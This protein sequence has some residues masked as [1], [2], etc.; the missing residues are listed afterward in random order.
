M[1]LA[2]DNKLHFGTC[3]YPDQWPRERWAIDLALMRD[4]GLTC[5]RW[6]EGSWSTC[7]PKPGEFTWD[8]YD[9]VLAHCADAG[10]GV[11]M[12]TPCCAAPIWFDRQYPQALAQSSDGSPLGRSGRQRYDLTNSA[13][14][15]HA[16]AVVDAL[17]E[18]YAGDA[19][20]WAWQVNN[21]LWWPEPELHGESVTTAF[22]AWLRDR[23][24]SIDVLNQ[25]WG[26]A[27]WSNQLTDFAQ[28]TVPASPEH[29]RN[30][31][32]WADYQRFLSVTGTQA[33]HDLRAIITGYNQHAVVMLNAPS[34]P[35][36][37]AQ[38]LGGVDAYG[39]DHFPR[40]LA[41]P[42]DRPQRGRDYG[43]FRPYAERLWAAEQQASQVGTLDT[44][45][46]T[47]PP[48]QL[49]VSALQ[50]IAHGCNVVNWFRWRTA[51]A[52]HHAN[53]G[54]LI[55]SWGE[56]SW[57][58]DEAAALI[59]SLQPHSHIIAD[60]KPQ[61]D[62]ARLWGFD[63]EVVAAAEPW[64]AT[65]LIGGDVGRGALNNLSLNEDSI[66]PCDLRPG[67]SYQFAIMPLA[68]AVSQDDIAHLHAW[69]EAGGELVLGPMAGHRDQNGQA[70][71]QCQPPGALA[72]LT[73]TRNGDC[74]TT[75]DP[76]L[77]LAADGGHRFTASRYAEVVE[78]V[79][80]D[81]TI[82]ARH[83]TGWLAA[84]GAIVER[85]VGRGKVI[86]SGVALTDAVLSW[87]WSDGPL[88]RPQPAM[89][90]H[91]AAAEILVRANHRYA[92]YFTLNHG[93]GPAVYYLHR[94]VADLMTGEQQ[95]NS[96]TLNGFGWRILIEELN[97]DQD[98]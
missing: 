5:V 76:V 45:Q 37:R 2:A 47:S 7:E 46:P 71:D 85:T 14:Q 29:G 92:L 94:P 59:R 90:T 91:E 78:P 16:A 9:E 65:A 19:R 58:F 24:A 73:G 69:V 41:N 67:D 38:M 34:W 98:V 1:H 84:R 52:S 44:R 88:S 82:I 18:R 93:P 3:W 50:S 66:R 6:G 15:Q 10:L 26:L 63:Q 22:Q 68:L 48:G 56:P 33:V 86:H 27:I 97:A 80:A 89:V 74:T 4:A 12:A 81:A 95:T 28:A 43:L 51:P 75:Y 62:V 32:Q 83:S 20:V 70:S 31:H 17:A 35:M 54:G 60:T 25:R 8:V 23:Y 61:I 21:P 40:L 64:I 79:A 30:Q 36:D 53:W 96:F 11:I 49:S 42:T 57:H 13:Y 77:V 55:P 39:H 72:S 87:L